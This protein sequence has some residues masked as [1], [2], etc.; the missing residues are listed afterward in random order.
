MKN[1]LLAF[2]R[3]VGATVIM[4]SMVTSVSAKGKGDGAYQTGFTRWRAA[5]NGFAGWTFNGVRL[6]AGALEFDSSTAGTG[7]DP[8]PAGQYNGGNYYNAGSFRVGEATSPVL[9]TSFA[10]Q[11][12]IASWNAQTPDGSWVETL[13]RAHAPHAP[14]SLR[15]RVLA[16]ESAWLKRVQQAAVTH[17]DLRRLDL[18]LAEVLEPRRQLADH[19]HARQEVKIAPHGGFTDGHGPRQFRAIQKTV[20][21]A[22]PGTK[23]RQP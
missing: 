22:S 5:E 15:A 14:E 3:I 11:E 10:F 20:R 2:A 18:P 7:M 9:P 8:Y 17:V 1:R 13:L 4:L 12:A 21:Q 19:E 6:N 23:L 16:L